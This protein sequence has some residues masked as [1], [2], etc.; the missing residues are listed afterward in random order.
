MPV[1]L[2]KSPLLLPVSDAATNTAVC[3]RA[4]AFGRP[5]A[6]AGI[7]NPWRF[8]QVSRDKWIG[9]W[10]PESAA[11]AS[12]IPPAIRTARPTNCKLLRK[13]CIAIFQGYRLRSRVATSSQTGFQISNCRAGTQFISGRRTPARA[14]GQP[15]EPAC[16]AAHASWYARNATCPSQPERCGYPAIRRHR[17]YKTRQPPPSSRPR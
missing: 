10:V 14:P 2:Q 13:V 7:E 4:P 3:M 17:K 15:V 16:P 12:P 11:M 5:M 1:T 9:S 6:E 8:V